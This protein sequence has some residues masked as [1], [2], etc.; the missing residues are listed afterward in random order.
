MV[1]SQ[2]KGDDLSSTI[3]ECKLLS[4]ELYYITSFAFK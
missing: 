1:N 3:L 2:S 4:K